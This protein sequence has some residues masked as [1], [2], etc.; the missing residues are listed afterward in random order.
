MYYFFTINT[1]KRVIHCYLKVRYI[2]REHV[3]LPNQTWNCVGATYDLA[4]F[5]FNMFLMKYN[6]ELD[7]TRQGATNWFVLYYCQVL[8]LYVYVML[9]DIMVIR[10]RIS[11]RYLLSSQKWREMNIT[12]L[13]LNFHINFYRC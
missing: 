13:E 1:T 3:I 6:Q 10:T 7:I 8:Y 4:L 2:K 5:Y 9:R 11:L 12:M